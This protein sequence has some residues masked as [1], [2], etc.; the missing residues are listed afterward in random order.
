MSALIRGYKYCLFFTVIAFSHALQLIH[1]NFFSFHS[2]RT[3]KFN[4]FEKYFNHKK[5]LELL[6]SFFFVKL[7]HFYFVLLFLFEIIL[8]FFRTFLFF[9]PEKFKI[10]QSINFYHRS[11]KKISFVEQETDFF[12]LS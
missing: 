2:I 1:N 11:Q 8:L 7:F 12:L 3:L 4:S 5:A 9:S 10:F 6:E